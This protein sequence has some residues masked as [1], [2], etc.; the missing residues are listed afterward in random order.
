[1]STGN[2]GARML[3]L[4]TRVKNQIAA[5]SDGARLCQY[6]KENGYFPGNTYSSGTKILYSTSYEIVS[7]AAGQAK[8]YVGDDGFFHQTENVTTQL[9]LCPGAT[10]GLNGGRCLWKINGDDGYAQLAYDVVCNKRSRAQS[11]GVHPG[12]TSMKAAHVSYT[13]STAGDQISGTDAIEVTL[14]N[15]ESTAR[16]LFA[17]GAGLVATLFQESSM[18]AGTAEVFIDARGK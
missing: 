6:I 5:G 16:I 8:G 9:L 3:S 12:Y 14:T 15:R 11:G 4:D 17:K 10:N 18:P 7:D 2:G 13:A 1:M